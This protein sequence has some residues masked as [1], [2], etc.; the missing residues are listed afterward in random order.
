MESDPPE[1]ESG[2]RP[3]TALADYYSLSDTDFTTTDDSEFEPYTSVDQL[4]VSSDWASED[5]LSAF[6]STPSSLAQ[7]S[8]HSAP[9]S[10]HM[11]SHHLGREESTHDG[12]SSS[13]S[14]A[15]VSSH[16]FHGDR[17][18]SHAHASRRPRPHSSGGV[19][20]SSSTHRR[21]AAHYRNRHY[22][23]QAF[24]PAEMD[25]MLRSCTAE[26]DAPPA[27]G[28]MDSSSLRD[29]SESHSL[30]ADAP[31]HGSASV[32][33]S[34]SASATSSAP[35]A[36]RGLVLDSSTSP[37]LVQRSSS[38][39]SAAS[40]DVSS[41]TAKHHHPHRHH[42]DAS[43]PLFSPPFTT[44]AIGASTIAASASTGSVASS[45]S[46]S[47]SAAAPSSSLLLAGS[48]SPSMTS[49][50]FASPPLLS[51]S[52]ASSLR[53]MGRVSASAGGPGH[54]TSA[55]VSVS[56]SSSSLRSSFAAALSASSTLDHHADSF[57]T[58]S[59]PLGHSTSPAANSSSSSA[60]SSVAPGS[61]SSSSS[62]SIVPSQLNLHVDVGVPSSSSLASAAAITSSRLQR[63]GALSSSSSSL[64]SSAPPM[65]SP[66]GSALPSNPFASGVVAAKMLAMGK[67]E[68]QDSATSF[69]AP[70]EDDAEGS[71][72][73]GLA[74]MMLDEEA[75]LDD[76]LLTNEE[77]VER[78]RNELTNTDETHAVISN[79][80]RDQFQ[81]EIQ[82]KLDEKK[83]IE[84]RIQQT[85][86]L[87]ERLRE[88]WLHSGGSEE[89]LRLFDWRDHPQN[90]FVKV[91][92]STVVRLICP[93]CKRSNFKNEVEL[94]NHCRLIHR[95][96]F[97]SRSAAI[98]CCGVSVS[99]TDADVIEFLRKEAPS[100][101]VVHE[102]KSK[103]KRKRVKFARH[104]IVGNTSKQIQSTVTS[105]LASKAEATYRWTAFVRGKPGEPPL[106]SFISKVRFFLHE[107]YAPSTVVDVNTPPFEV[108]REG[109]GEFPVAIQLHFR[110]SKRNRPLDFKHQLVLG[111]KD[112]KL[113]EPSSQ[114]EIKSQKTI[115]IQL[116]RR[117][118]SNASKRR[119]RNPQPIVC[120]A[121]ASEWPVRKK[122]HRTGVSEVD[123]A[124]IVQHINEAG[125]L[126]RYP[127]VALAEE[128]NVQGRYVSYRTCESEAA[129]KTWRHARRLA[130]EWQRARKLKARLELDIGFSWTTKQLVHWCREQGHTP[131]APP[132]APPPFTED[133]ELP[134]LMRKVQKQTKRTRPNV[135]SLVDMPSPDLLHDKHETPLLPADLY[136]GVSQDPLDRRDKRRK[137]KRR[138]E[139]KKKRRQ[140]LK[141][142]DFFCRY[143][144]SPHDPFRFE[145]LEEECGRRRGFGEVSSYCP[146]AQA[147][148]ITQIVSPPSHVSP[149]PEPNPSRLPAQ[150]PVEMAFDRELC[151]A[152]PEL[153]QRVMNAVT[154]L[155]GQ[156]YEELPSLMLFRVA[157]QFVL[158]LTAASHV[159]YADEV[160]QDPSTL[161]LPKMLVPMHVYQAVL[162]GE[163]FD[164]LTNGGLGLTTE[165]PTHTSSAAHSSYAM[166]SMSNGARAWDPSPL[167]PSRP[168][169]Q[170]P[171]AAATAVS[172]SSSSSSYTVGAGSG[173]SS[174]AST[175]NNSVV[176][177]SSP[178]SASYLT[179][180]SSSSSS[181]NASYSS[182]GGV[183]SAAVVPGSSYPTYAPVMSTS[184]PVSAAPYSY[185]AYSAAQASGTPYYA[186]TPSDMNVSSGTL[187]TN[188]NAAL[189]IPSTRSPYPTATSSASSTSSFSSS[190]SS[191]S[192]SS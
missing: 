15:G 133:D 189:M 168:Y 34:V 174:P 183:T 118:H 191:S 21:H 58:V 75:V 143:C 104:I 11:L 158:E 122:V 132:P 88:G 74:G 27:S 164:F 139:K 19:S 173:G 93:T 182:Y 187:N 1:I 128:V 70:A 49:A 160:A 35:G 140:L 172:S 48:A 60:S 167:P 163:R 156:D 178:A 103:S 107:S 165:L 86:A 43:A 105:G 188:A 32:Y 101:P 192:S 154:R 2:R 148:D 98:Q 130:T 76:M 176:S 73:T 119:K 18:A 161:S 127:I 47:S 91:G 137:R 77:R 153:I 28:V 111:S 7:S 64:Y 131:Y 68:H 30:S 41:L 90:L 115:Q 151:S 13:S 135:A 114:P 99:P 16:H 4:D 9:S 10:E 65:D 147:V 95:L 108:T 138:K 40:S 62:S 166:Q 71:G 184:Y 136:T 25:R 83:L 146:T 109:W 85:K 190:S 124:T 36:D 63:S 100:K 79:I 89:Q 129:W 31:D 185:G 126:E 22:D 181:A 14:S 144:G 50:L 53:S 145:L 180:P 123:D 170:M 162:S 78:A 51:S 37:G 112:D 82:Y 141:I 171:A 87:L 125:L 134:D 116:E 150:G 29:S 5:L 142:P 67:S 179:A 12:S 24:G 38:A 8:L 20:S 46:A 61:S 45:S 69:A 97:R 186:A 44:S 96:S 66:R 3:L 6:S 59:A 152:S 84:D 157:M 121:P 23:S 54:D 102:R 120:P 80:V 149:A 72:V 159:V 57:A 39:S 175:V 33:V 106:T 94:L 26:L 56:S 169:P 52:S 81:L 177:S 55:S 155:C 92:E 117:L 110:E 17:L 42:D 113:D